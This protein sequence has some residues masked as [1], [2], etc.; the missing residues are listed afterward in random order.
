MNHSKHNEETIVTSDTGGQKGSKP[1]QL[2]AIPWE[3]LQEVGR[4]YHY[5]TIKYDDYNFRKG[6]K[7]SLT[8]DAMQRHLW[9]FWSGEDRD[10]ESGFY[11]LAHAV[12]HGFTL[13]FYSITRKGTDDRPIRLRENVHTEQRNDILEDI[14]KAYESQ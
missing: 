8:F 11:H 5:G 12:W 4:V 13:L 3:A 9:A 6:Y 7:W 2:H 1:I 10:A 14:R